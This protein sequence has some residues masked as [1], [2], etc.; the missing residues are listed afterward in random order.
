MRKL[1][2]LI[3]ITS[4]SL[5]VNSFAGGITITTCQHAGIDY[6]L[7]TGPAICT[8]YRG[9]DAGYPSTWTHVHS[10][11]NTESYFILPDETIIYGSPGHCEVSKSSKF[12][13]TDL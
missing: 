12:E 10:G 4:L 9:T 7:G 13:D 6:A 3:L 1:N 8:E 2:Q 5:T 11:D